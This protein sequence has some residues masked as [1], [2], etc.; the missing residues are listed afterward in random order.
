MANSLP[1]KKPE[2]PET[3][4][5]GYKRRARTS[6]QNVDDV[7]MVHD[8]SNWLVSY[9]DMMTL[10]FGFFVLLYTFSRIDE[11]KFEVVRKDVARYFGGQVK[12]NPTVRKLEEEVKDVLSQSGLDKS[13]Q[14]IARDSEL[15]LRFQGTLHFVS[16]TATMTKDSNFVLGKLIDL[17][18][19]SVKADSVSVEGHTDDEPIFSAM[20]P[21]NW[22]L[23]AARAST[24]VRE[25]EKYGFDPAKLTAKGFGA[26]RPLLPNRDSKGDSIADN[27]ELNR[28]VIVTIGFNREIEDAIR[29]MKT[30]QFVSADAPQ[31]DP[32]KAKTSLVREGEGEPTWREKVT[33]DISAVNDKLKVAE[34]RLKETEERNQQAKQLAEMQAKLQQVEGKIGTEETQTESYI[35]QAGTLPKDS[36][37]NPDPSMRRPASTKTILPNAKPKLKVHSVPAAIQPTAKVSPVTPVVA[38]VKTAAVKTVATGRAPARAG[39]QPPTVDPAIDSSVIKK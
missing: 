12:V 27:Q 18:K 20:Y 8:E 37:S 24:V 30:N 16:G 21:S 4:I 1:N 35:K 19:R 7:P 29:A 3:P 14:L 34:E 15:E 39:D 11:K 33:R 26:S 17:I 10:L 31:L 36:K 22:E 28:R 23:S 25:F 38:P 13:V 32:D 6:R 5:H 2:T 9:A